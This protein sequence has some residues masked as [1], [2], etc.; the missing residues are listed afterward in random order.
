MRKEVDFEQEDSWHQPTQP[1]INI[2]TKLSRK[3]MLDFSQ[4]DYEYTIRVFKV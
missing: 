1:L 2:V 3:F 4:L